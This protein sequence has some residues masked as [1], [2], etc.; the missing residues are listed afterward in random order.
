LNES[1]RF[2]NHS[3]LIKKKFTTEFIPTCIYPEQEQCPNPAHDQNHRLMK[4][5]IKNAGAQYRK[6][7][8]D[9]AV[10]I[11]VLRP[12]IESLSPRGI[13][14]NCKQVGSIYGACPKTIRDIW[15]KR[16]WK[17]A[18]KHLWTIDST[19]LMGN[20]TIDQPAAACAIDFRCHFGNAGFVAG[21]GPAIGRSRI[22]P[23]GS[24]KNWLNITHPGNATVHGVS[25]KLTT[26]WNHPL[27]GSQD[28]PLVF[29][30]T[31]ALATATHS[32]PGTWPLTDRPCF[33]APPFSALGFRPS[34]LIP[35]PPTPPP[36][37]YPQQ[38]SPSAAD[39]MTMIIS[40][41]LCPAM[42]S[43]ATAPPPPPGLPPRACGA[44]LGPLHA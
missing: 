25:G 30:S 24:N 29:H 2:T 39:L 21:A 28:L 16:T 33:P 13:M 4:R 26:S 20:S 3:V 27:H 8:A 6:L 7:T 10:E 34:I 35:R 22:Q 15:Q 18:T 32:I 14:L 44:G 17:L 38:Q 9:E 19:K 43:A 37:L 5:K 31:A 11:F 41:L 40:S 36:W 1:L 23:T 12:D 42:P